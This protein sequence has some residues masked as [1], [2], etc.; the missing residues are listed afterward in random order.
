ME[1][2]QPTT[3]DE[4]IARLKEHGC[5]IDN[6]TQCKEI[7]S[8]I[9]YYRLSAYFLP[10]RTSDNHYREGTSFDC[11]YSIYEIDRQLRNIIFAAIEETEVS[12]RATF[13]YYHSHKY[14]ALG[15][16]DQSNFGD[17]HNHGTY[18]DH[19]NS[20]IRS[21]NTVLFV[22]HHNNKYA[23]QFPFWVI[24]ELFT[25]GML[26]FFYA[27]LPASDQKAIAKELGDKHYNSVRSWL[28]CC[29]DLRNICA[30]YGRL[31]YRTFP[32]VPRDIPDSARDFQRKLFG[33]LIALKGLFPNKE[34]WNSEVVPKIKDLIRNNLDCVNLGD[35]GLPADWQK[36][37]RK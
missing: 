15:Y 17:R 25:F 14:G 21:N 26:S 20:E 24:S 5:I 12:L 19:I 8:R 11:V 30:H 34:K 23:G 18:M 4:Q 32:S 6:K 13:S 10:F 31:Y 29:T 1:L 16:L 7:L 28:K 22:K 36:H 3:Y 37:L 2:K 33:A 9:S 27:D 35:L